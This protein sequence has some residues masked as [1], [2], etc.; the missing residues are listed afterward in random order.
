MT[1]LFIL[2]PL[3]L[4]GCATT[5]STAKREEA[6]GTKVTTT[7]TR[8]ECGMFIRAHNLDYIVD[9][10]GFPA[11]KVTGLDVGVS[12]ETAKIISAAVQGAVQGAAGMK[13]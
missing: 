1:K 3:L 13:P 4:C 11:V 10:N 2:L 12:P 7:I 6:N 5:T 9:T 8:W